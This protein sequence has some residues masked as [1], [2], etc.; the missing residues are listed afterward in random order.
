MFED[1]FNKVKKAA[2]QT[3]E[4]AGKKIEKDTERAVD[5]AAKRWGKQAEKT[6]QQRAASIVARFL[7]PEP[8]SDA[9]YYERTGTLRED[10][11][12]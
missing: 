2:G 10:D 1:F 5:K 12:G 8:E 7:S 11:W 3:V 6:A 4:G 9:A